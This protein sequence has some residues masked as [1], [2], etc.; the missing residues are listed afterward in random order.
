MRG[1]Y[2]HHA[3]FSFKGRSVAFSTHDASVISMLSAL[4]DLPVREH[5]RADHAVSLREEADNLVVHTSQGR[6]TRCAKLSDAI[7]ALAQTIPFM[8]LPFKTDYVLHGGAF[9]TGGKAHLFLGPGY[10]GKSTL[11]LEAWFMGYEIL[12]DDYLLFDLSTATLQAVPKPLKLRKVDQALLE[13]LEKAVVPHSYCLGDMGGSSTLILSRGLPRMVA[14]DRKVPI[15]SI[16]LLART[17]DKTSCCHPADKHQFFR[18]I[19]QQLVAA[20]RTNLDILKCL[21]S[22]FRD[23]RVS[24]L[25]IGENAA[26]AAVAA[27]V[28]RP[29][30]VQSISYPNAI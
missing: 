27:M 25:H 7:V 29:S 26:A 15:G 14:L 10:I 20:P 18:A 30:W 17:C 21:S 5:G 24:A 2:I 12:G 16:H 8:L 13:R 28:T 1:A 4:F 11:A 3:N 6:Q 19:Y 23:G 22:M 9:I